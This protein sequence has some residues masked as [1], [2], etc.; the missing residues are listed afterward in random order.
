MS[1]LNDLLRKLENNDPALAKDLRREVE[2]L[3]GRRAF[4]LNFERHVP[5][6]VELPGRPVR[7]GDKVRILPPRGS[8]ASAGDDRL[9]RVVATTKDASGTRTASLE[10]LGK[11]DETADAQVDDLVVVA[12]FRDPIY[13]GLVSTGKVERGGDKPYHAVINA[14]NYHAL[15]TLLFTHRAK[16]DAIYIDPPYNTGA[17]DW[18]YNNDYVEGEDLYRHSKWLAFM[19]RRLKLA[20]ELLNPDDSVLIVTID[21]KEYLRLGLLLEQTFPEARIQ[22]ISSVINPKGAARSMAFS[23][24]DEYIYFVMVGDA[25]PQALPISSDWK[26]VQDARAQKLRWAE[27]LRSASVRAD[28]PNLFYPVYVR[29][30][31]ASPMFDSVG[32]P[33]YG[34][35]WEQL[36]GPEGCVAIWP[37]RQN[38]DE[39]RWNIDSNSLRKLIS[40][41]YAKLGKWRGPETAISYLKKGEQEKVE[42]GTFPVI[43]RAAD[44]SVMVDS[45]EYSPVFVPGSQWRV[46]SHEA[47]GS[48]GS[49]LLKV[50]IPGRM[51]P[52]PK[53][54]YACEDA[55]RFFVSRKQSAVVVDFF[56]G[57]GTT[58]HAVMRLNRAD[59]GDRRA[60]LVTNNE[61]GADEQKKLSVQGLRPGDLEWE[62][63]GICDYIT[64]PRIAAAISGETPSGEPI[65]G[66]Y[67]FTDE[68]P[69]ADGFE[70]N[71][72]FFTLTYEA[73]L[74]VSSNREF[75][76]IAPLL[77]LRAG[78]AGRRIED[79]S[80]GWDVAD[81]YGVLADLNQSELFVKAI[82]A[83]ERIRIVFIVT[84][85]DRLFESVVREL[86]DHVEPVRLYEA[87]LQN[88]EIETGRAAL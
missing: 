16:V 73:P 28:R 19:E 5:E 33:Y 41:G 45:S 47:G 32:E 55:L 36:R 83:D 76:K 22:M 72:E 44:G 81:T 71:V 52:Y 13:P 40:L 56:A 67:K 46:G 64:K 11:Q 34:D 12:E 82:A 26:I 74:R 66:D 60:V 62:A 35:G 18:K 57:S 86:P 24:T 3:S 38:G 77:W 53:S 8:K 31:N 14:E 43:G 29:A 4:G 23:R 1:R 61:V 49:N 2:T 85:E 25:A 80:A 10:L 75:A 20:K 6:A 68:F 17:K 54:L 65:K 21:E 58:A 69:M 63:Y 70:E 27:L 50:L 78:S 39:G 30:D 48:G 15:Q 59:G 84:D 88:F 87:Y 9:W 7:R 79:I 42:A 51:F 37:I